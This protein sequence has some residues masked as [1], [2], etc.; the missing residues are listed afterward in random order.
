MPLYDFMN[1]ET[2]EQFTAMM[3]IAA[4]EQFLTDNPHITSIIGAPAIVGGTSF[5]LKNDNGWKENLS[6]IAAAHPTS[7][8]ADKLGGRSSKQVKV[9][10]TAAKHGLG[11]KGSYTMNL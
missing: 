2:G 7:A 9:E 4:K 10:Q 6:R 11:K 1:N 8:L 5:N 3:S